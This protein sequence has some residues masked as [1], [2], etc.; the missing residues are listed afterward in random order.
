[1]YVESLICRI[2]SEGMGCEICPCSV[3]Q[4]FDL[5]IIAQYS[6]IGINSIVLDL[7]R[8][9]ISKHVEVN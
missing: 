4:F 6:P 8:A 3:F 9:K 5:L 7:L 2:S 1:M